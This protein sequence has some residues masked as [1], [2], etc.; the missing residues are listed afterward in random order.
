MKWFKLLLVVCI[1]I[2]GIVISS[3]CS[4]RGENINKGSLEDTDRLPEDQKSSEL[5][6]TIAEMRKD[7]KE[8]IVI[9]NGSMSGGGD[10]GK[11]LPGQSKNRP[12][13]ELNEKFFEYID[14]YIKNDLKISKKDEKG[15]LVRLS[16]DPRMNAIYDDEDKGFAKEYKNNNIVIVEYETDKE[17]IY[18]NLIVVRKST[19]SPWKVIHNGNSYK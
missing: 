12:D 13:I 9:K 11:R 7:Y 4:S 16:I 5:D 1:L 6:K 19:E 15:Y 18:S 10:D 14:N 3:G 17:N 8:S 2:S